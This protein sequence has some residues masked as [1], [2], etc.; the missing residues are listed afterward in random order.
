MI[1]VSIQPA[2]AAVDSVRLVLPAQA[3][4]VLEN[5]GKVFDRQIGQIGDR[6]GAGVILDGDAPLTVELAVEAGIGTEGYRIEDRQDGGVRIVGNDM[7]GVV[8]GTG[9][10]LRR[11]R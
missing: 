7:R 11:S 2:D 10:F 4:E 6:C 3:D 8:A 9:K 1:A 5:L